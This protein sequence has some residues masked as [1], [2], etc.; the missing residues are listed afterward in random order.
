VKTAF[1]GSCRST[2]SNLI[3]TKA[4]MNSLEDQVR[5]EAIERL[6]QFR[7]GLYQSLTRR[8]DALFE[9][10]EAVLCADGP[11]KTLVDLSLAP[12][13]GVG[14]APSMTDPIVAAWRWRGSGR[15]WPVCRCRVPSMADRAG[16]GRVSVVA[17]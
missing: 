6:S 7:R 13:I 1:A 10:A 16:G 17:A 2:K 8:A 9:L 15:R 3:P 11:V 4:V 12:S 5:A 14:T